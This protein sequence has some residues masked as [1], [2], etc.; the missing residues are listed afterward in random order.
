MD[1]WSLNRAQS[2]WVEQCARELMSLNSKL[3]YT[4]AVELAFDLL[5]VWPKLAPSE[6]ACA[7]MAPLE[8]VS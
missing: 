4:G 8:S 6:A 5:R 7:Y 3:D 1:A 2:R